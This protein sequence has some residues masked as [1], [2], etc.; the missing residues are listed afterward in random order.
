MSEDGGR[1]KQR[2]YVKTKADRER[3]DE[4]FY[5]L[6]R[7]TC[8]QIA[9]SILRLVTEKEHVQNKRL[10]HFKRMMKRAQ[11]PDVAKHITHLMDFDKSESIIPHGEISKKLYADIWEKRAFNLY[12]KPIEKVEYDEKDIR[13]LKELAGDLGIEYKIT[14]EEVKDHV[15]IPDI[16]ENITDGLTKPKL[17]TSKHN[18]G[19]AD[20]YHAPVGLAANPKVLPLRSEGHEQFFSYDGQWTKGKMHGW[21]T[22]L[23]DDGFSTKGQF[24]NN[25][26]EG[27]ATA[28]YAGG[29]K[30]EGDWKRGRYYGRG[31]MET[32]DGAVYDGEWYDGRKEGRGRVDFPCGL[33]FEGGWLSGK[34]HGHGTMGSKSSKYVFEGEFEKGSIKG[35]G[36]LIT[37]SGE[38]VVRLWKDSSGKGLSLP[39]CVRIYLQEKEDMDNAVLE[40]DQK[41]YGSL[42]GMQ[43]T[44]YVTTVRARLHNER[45]EEK[46]RKYMEAKQAAKEH[47]A[48]LREARIRALAGEDSDEEE[49]MP[50]IPQ[51]L[52]KGNNDDD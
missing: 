21:G 3:Q 48:K 17:M 20:L 22:Y 46:K 45:T 30:Y 31:R 1:G 2:R 19:F 11:Y 10:H 5:E 42:R 7:K 26:P 44:D 33:Y 29:H 41:L 52:Q 13:A 47:Q 8:E 40:D 39:D 18:I 32:A 49:D 9:P 38:R 12:G 15:E 24:R 28:T 16:F 27:E 35:T 23:Y 4:L 6:P 36:T 50:E 34:P 43:M 51:E 25:W 14:K 37:P